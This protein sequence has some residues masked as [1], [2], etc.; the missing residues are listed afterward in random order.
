MFGAPGCVKGTVLIMTM[1]RGAIIL[2]R[3]ARA[4]SR[5]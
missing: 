4:L 3:G 2:L 1:Q 5:T